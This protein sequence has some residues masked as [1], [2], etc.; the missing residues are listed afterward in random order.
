M[1]TLNESIMLI[2]KCHT[3]FKA[4]STSFKAY[5]ELGRAA[6]VSSTCT[7]DFCGSHDAPTYSLVLGLGLALYDILL[8]QSTKRGVHSYD[9]ETPKAEL[10]AIVIKC[11]AMQHLG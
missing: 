5:A 10:V 9:C 8:L 7:M 4:Y 11:L 1:V 2:G 3:N 6:S